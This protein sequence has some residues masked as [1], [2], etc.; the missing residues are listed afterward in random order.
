MGGEEV[1]G[2]WSIGLIGGC[3]VFL[4]IDANAMS[5]K[6][7]IQETSRVTSSFGH[8]ENCIN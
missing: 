5:N 4:A 8:V 1:V 3:L 6:K 2:P 7:Y